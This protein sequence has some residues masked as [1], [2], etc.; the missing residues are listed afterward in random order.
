MFGRRKD[1]VLE[2]EDLY[3]DSVRNTSSKTQNRSPI[4][5]AS[6]VSP[7]KVTPSDHTL[8]AFDSIFKH[9]VQKTN[10]HFKYLPPQGSDIFLMPQWGFPLNFPPLMIGRAYWDN[11]MMSSLIRNN[12]NDKCLSGPPAIHITQS[13]TSIHTGVSLSNYNDRKGADWMYQIG[14]DLAITPP[15][16][17]QFTQYYSRGF[18]SAKESARFSDCHVTVQS[19]RMVHVL[20]GENKTQGSGVHVTK[21]GFVFAKR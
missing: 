17:S 4:L 7:L 12:D 8:S 13:L 5:G 15:G 3:H 10:A 2:E 21:S 1:V 14:L 9:V 18:C 11:Q 16:T 6:A 19:L 20:D